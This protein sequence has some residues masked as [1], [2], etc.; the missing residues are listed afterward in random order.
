[1]NVSDQGR[2]T[3]LADHYDRHDTAEEMNGGRWET[4]VSP[5]P[6]ITTSLRLPQRLMA[7]VRADARRRG[8]K[9]SALIREIIEQGLGGVPRQRDL[10][11]RVRALEDAI[12]P[13]RGA[14]SL[15]PGRD[16]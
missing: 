14:T 10:E 9:P 16:S 11:Q 1:M 13:H 4:D 6:M 15:E 3:E 5:E 12:R 2:W 7:D 8:M